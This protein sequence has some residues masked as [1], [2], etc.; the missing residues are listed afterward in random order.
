MAE[1][2]TMRPDQLREIVAYTSAHRP[3]GL[4]PLDVILEGNSAGDRAA[5]ADYEAAGL[6]WYVEKLGWWSGSV[7]DVAAVI[8]RGPPRR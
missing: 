7:E 8:R 4:A 5:L 1:T 2:D 3:S 6:T